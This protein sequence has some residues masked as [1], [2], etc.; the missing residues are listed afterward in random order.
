M[1][2]EIIDEKRINLLNE[3]KKIDMLSDFSIGGGTGLSLQLG[4]RTSSDFDFF[5][6]KHFNTDVL[7]NKLNNKFKNEIEIIAKE[8]RLSI[9]DLFIQGIKVS[10]FEYSHSIL[11]ASIPF[12]KFLPLSLLSIKDICGMK[13]IAII[14]RGTKKDFFDMYFIIKY[15]NL[16]AES[17]LSLIDKKYHDENLKISLLYS[18]TYFD[19]AE[20]DILPLSFIDYS[21]EDIKH[22]FL[23]YKKEINKII[24]K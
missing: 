5:T 10:F 6:N 20:G 13:A 8:E 9:L 19:D 14:Q 4:L 7:L 24:N 11:E 15:L 12:E 1:H 21:W 3:L 22:F 16:S 2:L 18:I 23:N 17:L